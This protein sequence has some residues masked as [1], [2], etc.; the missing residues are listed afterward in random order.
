MMNNNPGASILHQLYHSKAIP[1]FFIFLFALGGNFLPYDCAAQETVK[2][3]HVDGRYIKDSDGRI[4]DLHGLNMGTHGWAYEDST[5][6]PTSKTWSYFPSEEA[7]ALEIQRVSEW[8]FSL[9]DFMTIGSWG[10]NLV[11]LQVPHY[12]FDSIGSPGGYNSWG[13]ELL[14]KWVAWAESCGL[15]VVIDM[16]VPHGG[17]QYVTEDEGRMEGK[18]LWMNPDDQSRFIALWKELAR[19]FHPYTNVLFELMNEPDPS[20]GGFSEDTWWN[21]AQGLIDAIRGEG[22]SN[23]IVVSNPIRGN[24]AFREL[25][26]GLNNLAYDFHFYEPFAFTHQQLAWIE[27]VLPPVDYPTLSA[28]YL[29]YT[30][31]TDP[32]SIFRGSDQWTQWC[33]AMTG[34]E[35]SQKGATHVIPNYGSWN[36]AGYLSYDN[37][38]VIIDTLS[39]SLDN[40]TFETHTGDFPDGWLQWGDNG[41]ENKAYI[42]ETSGN[43]Y[44]T[45]PPTAGQSSR[46]IRPDD[47]QFIPLPEQY[48]DIAIAATVKGQNTGNAKLFSLSWY[49]EFEYDRDKMVED[50]KDYLD[51]R[52]NHEVPILCLEYGAAMTATVDQGH[53]QWLEDFTEILQEHKIHSAYQLYRGF[54]S[55]DGYG[56]AQ[57][58]GKPAA[59]CDW[60]YE[61]VLPVLM[62]LFGLTRLPYFEDFDHESQNFILEDHHGTASVHIRDSEGLNDSACLAVENRQGV[63]PYEVQVKKV[64]FNIQD[65]IPYAGGIYLRGDH[66]GTIY[67]EL[68]REVE[69]WDNLGLWQPVD[70]TTEWQAIDFG[71]TLKGNPLPGEVRFS[72]MVGGYEGTV[73]IDDVELNYANAPGNVTLNGP[74]GTIWYNTPTYAWTSVNNADSYCLM[75]E[76]LSG[77][78]FEQWY[79]PFQANCGSGNCSATP[80][81]PLDFG[82]YIWRIQAWN[83]AGYGSRSPGMILLVGPPFPDITPI[84]YNEDFSENSHGF[85]LENHKKTASLSIGDTDGVDGSRGLILENREEVQQYEVQAK[86]LGF[87]IQNGEIY[88]GQVS[89]RGNQPGKVLLVM[90]RDVAPWD[91]LGLWMEAALT[92]DWQTVEFEFIAAGNPGPGE[93]RFT[94]MAGEYKGTVFIDNIALQCAATPGSEASP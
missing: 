64:G 39:V 92:T 56:I 67:L 78:L 91:N 4:V 28:K 50:L 49:Q 36:N 8:N 20:K 13:F 33:E 46:G 6:D 11:R 58:S 26:D 45:I 68:I 17:R 2:R 10:A 63:L 5:Y 59:E 19:R 74:S 93:V 83:D 9:K 34:N 3:L 30:I 94:I 62:D 72:I 12:Q 25:R 31:D 35:L 85:L 40:H 61:F 52:Q 86:K 70:L 42:D 37:C 51:F 65:G 14:E 32:S 24:I 16:H 47:G 29:G 41:D 7:L 80:S 60:K 88:R 48:H 38:E 15:Y 89:L 27:P 53:L 23:I 21:L 90:M 69:P 84:P 76:E 44:V 71:F 66:P 73:F 87:D 18:T 79:T 77:N 75:V 81:I 54:G 82:Y 1:C 22:A 55:G 43:H 57:C